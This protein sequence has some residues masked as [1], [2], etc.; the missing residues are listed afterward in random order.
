VRGGR[1]GGDGVVTSGA[2]PSGGGAVGGVWAG[3]LA[4]GGGGTVHGERAVRVEAETLACGLAEAEAEW[5]GA[6]GG[7][8]QLRNRLGRVNGEG[9]LACT[10][11]LMLAGLI[12]P[13]L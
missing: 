9:R 8:G 6:E 5:S 1:D 2:L 4:G 11:L 7:R 10:W 3:S 12:S 13:G